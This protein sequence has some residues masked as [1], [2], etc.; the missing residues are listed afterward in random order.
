MRHWLTCGCMREQ[1]RY[2]LIVIGF[3]AMSGFGFGL[4]GRFV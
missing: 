2:A 1:R 3:G 4:V